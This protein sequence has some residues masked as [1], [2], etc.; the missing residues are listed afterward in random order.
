MYSNSHTLWNASPQD[1]ANTS[2]CDVNS[3]SSL[4]TQPPPRF[5]FP[6]QFQPPPQY[7]PQPSTVNF[8]GPHPGSVTAGHTGLQDCQSAANDYADPRQRVFT[9]SLH[10]RQN[11][12]SF[13]VAHS[14]YISGNARHAFPTAPEN[15]APQSVTP[16]PEEPSNPTVVEDDSH[17][18]SEPSFQFDFSV[19]KSNYLNMLSQAPSE[20][21][22]SFVPPSVPDRQPKSE[23][24]TPMIVSQGDSFN[25]YVAVDSFSTMTRTQPLPYFRK[26]A[27]TS[28]P[29]LTHL[30]QRR[31]MLIWQAPVLILASVRVQNWPMMVTR[32]DARL[33]ITTAVKT[34]KVPTIPPPNRC[35]TFADYT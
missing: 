24:A 30:Y 26:P 23:P 20:Q 34:Q 1:D 33:Y 13:P 19:L 22:S 32:S 11:P 31:L 8:A 10:G 17:H 4:P 12:L 7:V 35:L 25:I 6:Q 5:I 29:R 9:L 3:E 16:A 14:H 15:H 21:P 28:Y 2:L 18:A 27:F